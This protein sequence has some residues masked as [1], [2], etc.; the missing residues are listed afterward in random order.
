VILWLS[1]LIDWE[2]KVRTQR[3]LLTDDQKKKICTKTDGMD[4]SG[5]L[6]CPLNVFLWDIACCHKDIARLQEAINEYWNEEI[7]V[8]V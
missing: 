7:E 1:G 2:E 6:E 5:C 3:K 8:D 4:T